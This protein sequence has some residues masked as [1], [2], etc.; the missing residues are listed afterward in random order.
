[1]NRRRVDHQVAGLSRISDE[2]FHRLAGPKARE[3]LLEGIMLMPS[4]LQDNTRRRRHRLPVIAAVSL[5]GLLASGAIGWA[6]TA[7]SGTDSVSVQCEIAGGDSIIPATSGDPVADCA[8]EWQRQTGTKPPTLRAYDNGHGAISVVPAT[9]TP[10]PGASPLPPGATQNVSAIELQES[11][12]D[13]VAGLNSRCYTPD[14]AVALVRQR[15]GD[16]GLSDWTVV[17]PPTTD[18]G[19]SKC[20]DTSIVDATSR[21]VLLRALNGVDSAG[22]PFMKL[23][24]RLRAFSGCVSLDEQAKRVKVA[25]EALGLTEAAH[26]F[27]LTTVAASTKCATVHETVGGTIFL[28]VRGPRG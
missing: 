28:T 6:L 24:A 12:D 9:D 26:E 27:Q 8:A 11:L 18:A 22:Q 19:S 13:Y 17:A 4:H 1:M 14:A 10:A 5:S 25:A 2:Q 23:A 3:D 15:L 21:S 20:V 7:S 16:S